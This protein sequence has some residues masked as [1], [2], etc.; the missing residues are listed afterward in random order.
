MQIGQ[1]FSEICNRGSSHTSPRDSR[2]DRT[3]VQRLEDGP[4]QRRHRPR[5]PG[6]EAGRG[7]RHHRAGP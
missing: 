7:L 1:L 4:P 3:G 5:E 6:S 2:L